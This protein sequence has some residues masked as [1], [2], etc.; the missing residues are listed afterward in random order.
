MPAVHSDDLLRTFLSLRGDHSISE[1]AG[2]LQLSK[3]SAANIAR[4]LKNPELVSRL[5]DGQTASSVQP[6]FKVTEKE[7]TKVIWSVGTAVRTQ[8]DAVE[9]AEI[10]LSIWEVVECVINGYQTTMKIAEGS[11]KAGTYKESP[12]QEQNWQ[13]K[14]KLRRRAPKFIQDGIK[15]LLSGFPT[16]QKITKP[17]KAKS[18]RNVMLEIA[19]Y[20]SHFAKLCWGR[21]TGHDYDLRIADEIFQHG[22]EDLLEASAHVPVQRI[23]FPVGNDFFH[24]NNWKSETAKGTPVESVDAR[25]S[26]VFQ[27]GVSAIARGIDAALKVA[28]VELVWIPGNHDPETSWYMTQVIKAMFAGNNH[29]TIDDGPTPRKYIDH[30]IVLLGLCHGDK[31]KEQKYPLLMAN[32]ASHLWHRCQIREIH[33][34]HLHKTSEWIIMG[35]DEHNGVRVRRLPSLTGTD[36]WHFEHGFVGNRRAAEAYQWCANDG[37]LGHCSVN[38]RNSV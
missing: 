19:M 17:P 22:V 28:P 10:D 30:G 29:V 26:K 35:A 15:D 18:S 3:G 12:H 8:A 13:V 2:M 37:Y 5:I 20:D 34:G 23:V 7:N 21:Q 1:L 31:V 24:A 36:S 16:F 33:L 11:K 14:V 38:V 9:K 27:Y 6:K 4:R 32:E 25:M